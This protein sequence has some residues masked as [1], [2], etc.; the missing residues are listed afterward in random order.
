M[1]ALR[2]SVILVAVVSL[3][4]Y[5]FWRRARVKA[6]EAE[7]PTME[8]AFEGGRD[9]RGGMG[10][11]PDEE[12]GPDGAPR[13]E[14]DR[15]P[16]AGPDGQA[17]SEQGG[18]GVEEGMPDPE[19]QPGTMGPRGGSACLRS[20]GSSAGFVD[21]T[22]S[23]DLRLVGNV[24]SG[25]QGI[26]VVLAVDAPIS[27]WPTAD[28]VTVYGAHFTWGDTWNLTFQAPPASVARIWLCAVRTS[29]YQEFAGTHVGGCTERILD[30]PT[31]ELVQ[32][33]EN[34][35][36]LGYGKL[37]SGRPWPATQQRRV[38][39]QITLKGK[40]PGGRYLVAVADY[41]SLDQPESEQNPGA[42]AVTA[43]TGRFDISLL[44]APASELYVCALGL[45]P[46]G[47]S[48]RTKKELFGM[49]CMSVVVP[50]GAGA[51]FASPELALTVDPARRVELTAHEQEHYDLLSACLAP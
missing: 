37:I 3:A 25:K 1:R 31:L 16:S 29:S 38:V 45:P 17:G 47:E 12:A 43:P 5:V 41:P 14:G 2:L 10:L 33:K 23:G 32:L 50:D 48:I 24:R 13:P 18:L 15:G 7:A 4:A 35:E 51:A 20:P 34:I 26:N 44:A 8:L 27:R 22:A 30:K 6:H 46:L 36:L 21:Y 9:A 19:G 40:P 11:A 28:S 42:I 49:G 39:G